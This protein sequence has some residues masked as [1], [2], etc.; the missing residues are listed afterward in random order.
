MNNKRKERKAKV[1][2][3]VMHYTNTQKVMKELTYIK[4][5]IYIYIYTYTSSLP[6]S[7]TFSSRSPSLTWNSLNSVN[8]ETEDR[9]FTSRSSI[10]RY[11]ASFTSLDRWQFSPECMYDPTEGLIFIMLSWMFA[12]LPSIMSGLRILMRFPT[13]TQRILEKKSTKS[14]PASANSTRLLL[15]CIK[16]FKLTLEG[17]AVSIFTENFRK[18]YVAV[19]FFF[20]FLFAEYV[21]VFVRWSMALYIGRTVCNADWRSLASPR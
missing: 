11:G 19:F 13:G 1:V 21:A 17:R 6:I 2:K 9:S 5:Y 12:K 3:E 8:R 10:T 14:L 15:L 16:S 18:L 7:T 4:I 20:L